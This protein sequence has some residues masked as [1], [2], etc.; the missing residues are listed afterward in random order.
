MVLYLASICYMK[1]GNY[2][3]LVVIAKL[4]FKSLNI[5]SAW[6]TFAGTLRGLFVSTFDL[7]LDTLV[8]FDKTLDEKEK[9]NELCAMYH[10]PCVTWTDIK[11]IMGV[12]EQCK[13]K[14]T[15]DKQKILKMYC[16]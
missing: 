8:Y 14:G 9:K 3:A 4:N 15:E 10:V 2:Q 16:R 12:S 11:S 7:L 13:S 1:D 6:K 5:I